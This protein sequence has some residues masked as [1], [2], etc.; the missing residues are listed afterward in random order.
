MR[1]RGGGCNCTLSPLLAVPV[2]PLQ[3]TPNTTTSQSP[4]YKQTIPKTQ[5]GHLGMWVLGDLINQK[6]TNSLKSRFIIGPELFRTVFGIALAHL[7]ALS[8]KL[9]CSF[10]WGI[11][12]GP[13][14][15]AWHLYMGLM[16]KTNKKVALLAHID[17]KSSCSSIT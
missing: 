14:H 2:H 7:V 1:L 4:T 5:Q 3:N 9:N 8:P 13:E 11:Q 17:I 15:L 16:K 10:L 6:V 12:C